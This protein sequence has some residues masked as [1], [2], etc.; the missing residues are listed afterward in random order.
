MAIYIQLSRN[1]WEAITD[2]S[3]KLINPRYYTDYVIL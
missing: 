1:P 3:I 2:T